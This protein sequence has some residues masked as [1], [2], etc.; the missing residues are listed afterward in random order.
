[1]QVLLGVLLEVL[2]V[3]LEQVQYW[4]SCM[5]E[6]GGLSVLGGGIMVV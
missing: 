6:V 4:C 2:L 1:V 3:L 5:L